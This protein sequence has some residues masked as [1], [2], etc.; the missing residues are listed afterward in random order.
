MGAIT[1]TTE[2]DRGALKR[3]NY[4]YSVRLATWALSHGAQLLYA[5][6]AATYGN[7]EQGYSD[8]D[9]LTPRLKPLNPYGESKQQ[10]DLWVL[11]EGFQDRVTGFKFFNVF[12]PNEYH[13]G[14][15]RSMVHKGYG[16]A[17][18]K[19]RIRLFKSYHPDYKDGAQERDFVYVKDVV[20]VLIWFWKHPEK[21]GIYNIGSGVA[22]DWNALAKAIFHSRGQEPNIEYFKMPES[23]RDQYQ[24]HTKADLTKLKAAGYSAPFRSLE[25]AIDDY[26]KLHLE[27]ANPYL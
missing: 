11:K 22:R 7:G 9:A 26:V 21:H 24:Y 4:E 13:K 20:D 23:I 14:D 25:Q 1:D 8:E 12:G 2:R 15:M 17:K 6:S 3:N 27:K 19:G 16:Q 5:S 10:F 18:E